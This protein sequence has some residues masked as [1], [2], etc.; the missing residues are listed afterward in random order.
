MPL[1][2]RTDDKTF[3]AGK[4]YATTSICDSECLYKFT[5]F[6]RTAKSVT[7]EVDGKRVRR[8]LSVYNGIEQFKPFGS[9]SMCAI[10]SADR[11]PA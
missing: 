10:I 11:V 5:V 6:A 4:S 7:V 1:T 8:G 9:Y 2:I 3:E